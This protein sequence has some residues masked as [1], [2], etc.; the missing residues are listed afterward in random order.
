MISAAAATQHSPFNWDWLWG[1]LSGLGGVAAVITLLLT[2]PTNLSNLF[3]PFKVT[4]AHYRVG[5]DNSMAITITVKNRQRDDRSLTA[6]IIGQPPGRWRRLKPKWW[7]GL[8]G[9][10]L[11]DID[12]D[13]TTLGPISSGDARTFNS[14]PLKREEGTE[15]SDTLPSNARVLAYSG[16]SRP[17]VKR[18]KKIAGSPSTASKPSPETT[19]APVE[20]SPEPPEAVTPDPPAS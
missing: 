1:L 2:I 9:S 13:I 15:V 12:I 16:A 14:L 18:P 20:N 7:F 8:K 19:A 3:A 5:A 10:K 4:S 11:F 17:Y 6:L